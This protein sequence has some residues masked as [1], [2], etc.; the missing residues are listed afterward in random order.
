[1]PLG[2]RGSGV[3]G[4]I[5]ARSGHTNDP[6]S[7][8]LSGPRARGTQHGRLPGGYG[9]HLSRHRFAHHGPYHHHAGQGTPLPRRLQ[10]GLSAFGGAHEIPR[11]LPRSV[12]TV[13]QQCADEIL[14]S[15]QCQRNALC[16]LGVA[17]SLDPNR[18]RTDA[19]QD[20]N[21]RAGA[22]MHTNCVRA[23]TQPKF[24]DQ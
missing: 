5:G 15:D 22:R 1:M 24:D 19:T 7:G 21:F 23:Q 14:A 8:P 9:C 6:L 11:L 12:N 3:Q 10:D 17:H 20:L 4:M 13:S 2:A 16:Q 18:V